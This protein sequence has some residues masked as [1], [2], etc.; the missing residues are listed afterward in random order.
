MTDEVLESCLARLQRKLGL[1]EPDEDE[2][3][4]LQDEVEDAEREALTYLGC[5][6][7]ERRFLPQVLE[8]AALYA[9][10]D[11]AE[12][13]GWQSYSYSEGQ[14]SENIT[15]LTEAEYQSGVAEILQ[16]LAR[17]RVVSC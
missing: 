17:Y 4:L 6:E 11:M 5:E 3:L 13:G 1:E 7:L 16:T 8:L 14:V 15:Y 12:N 9:Q 10:K 2:L